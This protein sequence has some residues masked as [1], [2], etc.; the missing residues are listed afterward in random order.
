MLRSLEYYRAD[1]ADVITRFER[2]Y[3]AAEDKTVGNL[4]YRALLNSD[5]KIYENLKLNAYDFTTDAGIRAYVKDLVKEMHLVGES[6]REME[7]DTLPMVMPILGIGDYSAFVDGEIIFSEDTSWSQPVLTQLDDWRNLPKLGTAVWYK[8]FMDICEHLLES[9]S[10]SNIPFMRG[11]FSPLDLAHALRGN[12][13]YY[14]FFDDPPK[15]HD[16]LS[17]CADA[18]IDFAEDLYSVARKHLGNSDIGMW[19]LDGYIN[20]SEDTACMISPEL[21]RTFAAPHTQKVIDHFG[22]G[23]LHCHS[24]A[25]YLVPEISTL[26]RA[27]NIWVATDP[28]ETRPID[29]LEILIPQADGVGLSLDI[30]SKRNI[31]DHIDIAKTGN[32]AFCSPV[33]DVKEGNEITRFVRKHSLS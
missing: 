8:R 6:R 15:V 14:D 17:Y 21:Y 9:T 29:V 22:R 12:E 24:R 26:H 5:I 19:F 23:L 4:V 20:M 31:M 28:N 27:V 16:L 33:K 13:I 7:D 32:I 25:L 18:T 3:Q 2:F 30:E 1:Y 10:S 11:F